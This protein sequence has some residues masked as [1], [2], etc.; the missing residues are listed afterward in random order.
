MAVETK[1]ETEIGITYLFFHPVQKIEY[2]SYLCVLFP[3]T[4]HSK[5][6]LII[7]YIK[8]I[9]FSFFRIL[10]TKEV[11]SEFYTLYKLH[12]IVFVVRVCV[13]FI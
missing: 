10:T 12:Y 1:V 11:P 3:N 7:N 13:P 6:S 9:P 5:S 8:I 2:F 4:S